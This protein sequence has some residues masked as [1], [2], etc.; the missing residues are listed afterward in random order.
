MEAIKQ[1]VDLSK[2][3][4]NFVI[5]NELADY[6]RWMEIINMEGKI[7]IRKNT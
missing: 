1:L 2:E 7:K 4:K 3:I 5:E 6:G